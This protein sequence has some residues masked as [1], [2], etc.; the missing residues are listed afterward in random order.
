M[1]KI[2]LVAVVVFLVVGLGSYWRARARCTTTLTGQ[3]VAH[4]R[5]HY[6]QEELT[7]F[8]QVASGNDLGTLS[9]TIHRW[10][11]PR[12]TVRIMSACESA[13]RREVVRVLQDLNHL[14]RST[15]F[16]LGTYAAPDLKI[17]FV[18]RR[19]ISHFFAKHSAN[20]HTLDAN[21]LFGF[22]T[23]ACGEIVSATV[24]VANNLDLAG[25]K[26]AIIREEL[27][28][29]IGLPKDT[30]R[31]AKSVFSSNRQIIIQDP[32]HTYDQF[33][34]EFLPI[35]EKVIDI[36]YNSGISINTEASDFTAQVLTQ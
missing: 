15:Q 18:P 35:D 21:G 7:Y 32:E 25:H 12:V 26:E 14:S 2:L 6:T 3:Q 34:T 10:N 30:K 4:L 36:L 5:T 13:E 23:S 24:A 8:R 19:E 17:Y 11:R 33:A 1:K 28:Q 9:A 27:A 22:E 16:V 20:P 29:S 31:Y